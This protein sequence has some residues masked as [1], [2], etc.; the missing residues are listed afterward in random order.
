[1]TAPRRL[2]R[3]TL[4]LL[5]LLVSATVGV[6]AAYA[7]SCV[8]MSP[9]DETVAG[10]EVAFSGE[11]TRDLGR[12]R[13]AVRVDRVF[14]GSVPATVTVAAEG[15]RESSCGIALTPGPIVYA[16][17]RDLRVHLCSRVWYGDDA[18]AAL[19]ASSVKGVRPTGTASPDSVAIGPPEEPEPDRQGPLAW[20]VGTL[21]L[22]GALAVLLLRRR[23]NDAASAAGTASAG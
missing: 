12:N 6:R 2:L 17:N 7:C 15:P 19:A 5:V 4:V 16:G 23:R 3:A 10:A 11:V 8:G 18:K 14:K 20:P 1:M 13:Y 21:L 22:S 9:L